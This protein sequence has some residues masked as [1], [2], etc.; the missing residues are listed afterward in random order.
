MQIRGLERSYQTEVDDFFDSIDLNGLAETTPTDA[1]FCQARQ[2]VKHTA[3]IELS[4]SLVDS[5]YRHTTVKDWNGMRI[6]AV[7]G[8][9]A[10]VPDT[11]ENLE[12]FGAWLPA[13]TGEPCPKARLSFAYDPLNK[14]LIDAIMG[15]KSIGEDPMAIQHLNKFQEGD[16]GIYDRGYFS[17]LLMKLHEIKNLKYCMRVPVEQCTNLCEDLLPNEDDIE[18]YYHPSH[19]AKKACLNEGVT[20]DSLKVRLVKIKLS[21]GQYEV[22]ATNIFDEDL[23]INDFKALYSLRWGVE[24]EFKRMKSRVEL[25]AYSGKLLDFVYQDFYADVIRLNISSILAKK[26]RDDLK[27]QGIKKRHIHA[28]NMSYVLPKTRSFIA[29]LFHKSDKAF[30]QFLSISYSRFK[31]KSEPIRPERSFPRIR[32]PFRSGRYQEYKIAR[33]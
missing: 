31:R 7:D 29:I 4:D 22:L 25:E 30:K 33:C 8:S 1:A 3:F 27:G 13:S 24:E 5:F 14:I 16:L 26:S 18:V 12:H 6:I 10:H 11:E 9:T 19:F 15:P 28:P 17:F 23:E 32:K 20:Y 21:P 2:K